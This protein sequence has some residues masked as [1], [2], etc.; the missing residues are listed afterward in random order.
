MAMVGLKTPSTQFL[1]VNSPIKKTNIGVG[2]SVYFD[3]IGPT[4]MSVLLLTQHT[5]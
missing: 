1:S 3:K 5:I 4:N 2:G